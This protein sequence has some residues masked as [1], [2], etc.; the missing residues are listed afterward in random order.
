MKNFSF[1]ISKKLFF[2]FSLNILILLMVSGLVIFYFSELSVKFNYNSD[3][4]NYKIILDE[5]RMEEAKLKGQTQSFYLN[6]ND[7]SIKAG[8]KKITNSTALIKKNIRALISERNNAINELKVYSQY[9]YTFSNKITDKLKDLN[10][11]IDIIKGKFTESGFIYDFEI[12]KFLNEDTESFDQNYVSDINSDLL[13]INQELEDLNKN[14]KIIA[15]NSI[16]KIST[17]SNA[18]KNI[19]NLLKSFD[20]LKGLRKRIIFKIRSKRGLDPSSNEYNEFLKKIRGGACMEDGDRGW[21]ADISLTACLDE[22][23]PKQRQ[24]YLEGSTGIYGKE[25]YDPNQTYAS[26]EI[27]FLKDNLFYNMYLLTTKFYEIISTEA[28]FNFDKNSNLLVQF[29]SQFNNNEMPINVNLYE[30]IKDYKKYYKDLEKIIKETENDDIENVL[31]TFDGHFNETHKSINDIGKVIVVSQI[32]ADRFSENN[33]IISKTLDDINALINHDLDKVNQIVK[34]NAG[35]FITIVLVISF[36]GLLIILF[37]GIIISRLITRPVNELVVTSMDIAQGKSDLTK[38]IE[39]KGKDEL[40]ELSSWFNMFLARLNNLV[41]DI[42]TH[43]LN[44]AVSSKEIAAGNHDLSSRTTQQSASLE[45]TATS[46]EEINSIVQNSA[47]DAKNANEITQKAQQTVVDSRTQLL[48]TVN[49]SIEINQEM[50]QDLQNTNKSVVKAMEQIMESSKKIEGIIT[51]MNDIA[52]Q[53]NLLALN[54]SV[55]AARAGEHGKGFAVVASEVRKLAHRSAKASKEIGELIQTSLE[56]INSGQNLVKEGEQ[57][58]DEMESKIETMLNKLK[59]E[60]DSNLDE[61]LKSVKEVSEMM[62]NIKVASQEQAEGVAQINKTI[63]D[64]DRITQENSALVEQNSAASQHMAQEAAQ[65]QTLINEFKV[66]EDQSGAIE[67][68]T[69]KI[70]KDKLELRHRKVEQIPEN[71]EIDNMQDPPEEL[72]NKTLPDFK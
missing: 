66:D 63:S 69:D 48:D 24:K 27:I 20:D 43:A 65:L 72:E 8:V 7:E 41:I 3:L 16:N 1:T 23:A 11:S 13:L 35:N 9:R 22:I 25:A 40:S 62:E 37:I 51:L 71:T 2:T 54:A 38:R 30:M 57:G 31:Y 26:E 39:V 5:I 53:T 46:M 44:M 28:N 36:V 32:Y 50:L 34:N 58:M 4:L 10:P 12:D 29:I 6:A 56:F 17:L 33:L 21:F 49:D 52:F 14:V 64:M 61:I 55:E 15:A 59:S 45:E 68:S 67:N 60:S 47:E 42:K 18:N 70:E 19:S